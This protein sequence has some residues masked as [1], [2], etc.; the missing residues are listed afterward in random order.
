MG[1]I[2]ESIFYSPFFILHFLF[3]E[4]IIPF[5]FLFFCQKATLTAFVPIITRRL[6]V[7]RSAN[8]H[9]FPIG[10]NSLTALS[11]QASSLCLV[12]FGLLFEIDSRHA[13]NQI[14]FSLLEFSYKSA[15]FSPQHLHISIHLLSLS[16]PRTIHRTTF[17]LAQTSQHFNS[18]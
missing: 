12:E 16:L 10:H 7:N 8:C 6:N 11:F 4:L 18:T 15:M 17:S 3:C 1:R 9:P 5:P 14:Y 13:I 2:A